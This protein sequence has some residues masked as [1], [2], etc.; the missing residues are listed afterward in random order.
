MTSKSVKIAVF[1]VTLILA[2]VVAW[3]IMKQNFLVMV[4]AI[5]LACGI[6][7]TLQ[8]SVKEV[9]CDER[10]TMLSDKAAAATFRICVPLAGVGAAIIL[11]LKDRLPADLVS[12]AY[13]L[14]YTACVLLGV[15][16]AFYLYY[17]RKH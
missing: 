12:A 5:V 6:T 8:K 13:G 3:A 14:A 4:I 15:N 10:T 7:Y 2:F 17:G 9:A 16:G 11:A 1:A